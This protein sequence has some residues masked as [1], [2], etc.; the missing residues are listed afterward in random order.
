[1]SAFIGLFAVLW[2]IASPLRTL[3]E[4]PKLPPAIGL[5][6]VGTTETPPAGSTTP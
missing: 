4:I 2:L 3:R 5:D 6:P 1:V